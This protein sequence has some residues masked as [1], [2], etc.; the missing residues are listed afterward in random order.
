MEVAASKIPTFF[1]AAPRSGFD[2][3]EPLD[4]SSL[5]LEGTHTD[6]NQ[7]HSGLLFPRHT[8][9]HVATV[10]SARCRGPCTAPSTTLGELAVTQK[11]PQTPH[12]RNAVP[13]QE[14]TNPA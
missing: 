4:C 13:G 1:S 14:Y 3:L 8:S 7:C 10:P 11:Q 2:S 5:P 12:P 6:P 9:V